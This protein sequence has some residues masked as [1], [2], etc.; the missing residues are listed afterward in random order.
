MTL[1]LRGT[2]GPSR[3]PLPRVAAVDRVGLP[4]RHGG[5]LGGFAARESQDSQIVEL[6][7][8]G[9]FSGLYDFADANRG[10]S[11]QGLGFGMNDRVSIARHTGFLAGGVNGLLGGPNIGQRACVRQLGELPIPRASQATLIGFCTGPLVSEQTLGGLQFAAGLRHGAQTRLL[12]LL[13]ELHD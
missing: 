5:A 4:R 12:F 2:T 9:G 8:F 10:D 11:A 13:F 3:D 7:A 6:A 1:S